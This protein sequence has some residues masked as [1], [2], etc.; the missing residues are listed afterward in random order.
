MNLVNRLFNSSLGQKYVMAVTGLALFGFVVGHLLGNLQVFGP[1]ELINAYAH[2]LKSK[3]LLLWGARL[4]LLACVG[5]HIAMAV[6]LSVAARAA[7]PV[8]YAGASA[9]AA[10]TASRY[11]LVSGLVVL[12]FI[13]YHLAHFTVLL[14]GINGVGDFRKL[15]T[16]LHGETVPD[17][18]GMM[19]LGFQ[20]PWV[21]L[22]YLVAQGLLL[23]HLGHGLSALFQSLGLRDHVWW[24]RIQC[25]ARAASLAIFIGY[26]IIP[27]AILTHIVGWEYSEKIRHQPK[28]AAPSPALTVWVAG[29]EAP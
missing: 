25:F 9:Y 1:P 5:L 19:I 2:F 7:R 11:M 21:A 17:V 27:L 6:R 10:S 13:G 29:K 14:P 16:V 26:A 22:F 12:A 20:V 24:P 18:Y 3:P 15:T 28:A 4:G 23:L 8:G